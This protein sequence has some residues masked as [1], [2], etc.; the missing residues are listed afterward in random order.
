VT[1]QKFGIEIEMTGLTR[2]RAAEVVAEHFG[3]QTFCPGGGY[4]AWGAKDSQGRTWKFVSDASID[5][6]RKNPGQPAEAV[7]LVSPI[8]EYEDIPTVQ[9][10]VRKLRTA[11]AISNKA[12]GIHVHVDASPHNANTLR[13]ITNIMASNIDTSYYQ[14][15][16]AL[17]FCKRTPCCTESTL[18]HRR[19]RFYKD[20]RYYPYGL[21]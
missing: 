20:T 18:H 11:G 4:D 21:S 17:Y 15:F 6:Q 16:Y 8:C 7:E 12:C 1:N 10:L 14:P 9:E 19:H 3:T 2:Q 5:V 13:N